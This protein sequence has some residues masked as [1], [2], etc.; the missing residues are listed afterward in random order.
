MASVLSQRVEIKPIKDNNSSLLSKKR[1]T[2][3][4][5]NEEDSSTKPKP[6]TPCQICKV[7]EF[8]Y[9]CPRCLYK[10]CSV[11]C[12]NKHKKKFGCNGQRDKFKKV[13]SQSEYDEKAFHRDISYM[14]STINNINMTN[15]KIFGLTEDIDKSQNKIF[16]NFKRICKKFRNITYY[17]SPLIMTCNKINKSYSDS[18]LK[19]IFWTVKFTFI[20]E[21]LEHVFTKRQFDDSEITLS[22]I[23]EYLYENKEEIDQVQLLSILK[24]KE[25]FNN[26]DVYF[27][28]NKELIKSFSP[29]NCICYNKYYYEKCNVHLKLMEVLNGK[30]IFEYPEFFLFKK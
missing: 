1:E 3:T 7:N 20:K 12:V 2:T 29:E 10:T 17:K 19:K 9:T 8:K 13:S 23:A 22:N 14:N 11:N 25:W 15:R 30:E 4:P 28:T 6:I 16:K 21:S 27:K 24:N 26:Y 18:S 5:N